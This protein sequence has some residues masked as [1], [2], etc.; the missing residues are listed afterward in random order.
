MGR[1]NITRSGEAENI[2]QVGLQNVERLFPGSR[3]RN[4]PEAM[5]QHEAEKA[6]QNEL[7]KP[8]RE[9]SSNIERT[10]HEI[11][12]M[13]IGRNEPLVDEQASR[14]IA[15]YTN[16]A[17]NLK[18]E[19]AELQSKGYEPGVTRVDPRIPVIMNLIDEYKDAIRNVQRIQQIPKSTFKTNKENV[20][21]KAIGRHVT[22]AE[23]NQTLQQPETGSSEDLRNDVVPIQDNSSYPDPV[24][25][26][27]VEELLNSD[28]DNTTIR[29]WF[30][31]IYVVKEVGYRINEVI[32]E[33]S[34]AISAEL[35]DRQKAFE[36][37]LKGQAQK[38]GT[39]WWGSK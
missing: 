37:M 24:S 20:T 13:G 27:K 11:N 2:T 12:R 35:T 28:T 23:K 19:L 10:T 1:P 6:A 4:G 22:G 21:T 38:S 33:K 9:E 16:R 14:L 36:V 17:T 3:L 15:R 18:A 29:G 5:A 8:F 32:A 26:E 25:A 30:Q 31:K 39:P 7:L 34:K